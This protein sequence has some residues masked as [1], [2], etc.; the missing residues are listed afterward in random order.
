MMGYMTRWILIVVM[1]VVSFVMGMNISRVKEV[2]K[3]LEVKI[4]AAP[5]SNKVENLPDL[6]IYPPKDIHLK[7]FILSLL[8]QGQ[9]TSG[10]ARQWQIWARGLL[11]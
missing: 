3:I 1:A 9:G 5:E 7:S 4:P 8:D 2:S 6:I 10:S 11:R